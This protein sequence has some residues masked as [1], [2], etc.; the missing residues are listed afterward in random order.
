MP[1][2]VILLDLLAPKSPTAGA[3]SG[4]MQPVTISVHPG[5]YPLQTQGWGAEVTVS[6]PP[7]HSSFPTL[8]SV[9][10]PKKVPSKARA[11]RRRQRKTQRPLIPEAPKEIPPEAVK[12]YADIMEGLVGSHL[13]T[14]ESDGKQEEEEQQQEEEGMYP[15]PGFLSYMDELCSQEVFVSKVSWTWVSSF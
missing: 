3:V 2:T 4:L 8:P 5:C 7:P 15:D 10:M 11:P 12:E 1:H 6:V 13:A 9:Y 14:G